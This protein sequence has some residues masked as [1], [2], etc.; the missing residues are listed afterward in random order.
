[1]SSARVVIVGGGFAGASA[2]DVL[3]AHGILVTLITGAPGAS[4]MTS[5]AFDVQSWTDHDGPGSLQGEEG[6]W[7]EDFLKRLLLLPQRDTKGGKEWVATGAGVIRPTTRAGALILG[8]GPFSGRRIGVARFLGPGF[9]SQHLER[10]YRDSPFARETGTQFCVVDLPSVFSASD[11]DLPAGATSHLLESEEACARLAQGLSFVERCDPELSAVLLPPCFGARFSFPAEF[12]LPVG[13]ILS[14]PEGAFGERVSVALSS[15]LEESP[16]KVV[17][18]NVS[19][20]DRR[21]ADIEITTSLV[22]EDGSG[23]FSERHLTDAL[24]LAP[25]GLIGGGI[26]IH[27]PSSRRPGFFGLFPSVSPPPVDG[28][29]DGF[30]AARKGP[31]FLQGRGKRAFSVLPEGVHVAGE[32]SSHAEDPVT[33]VIG[34]VLSGRR[35]ALRVLEDLKIRVRS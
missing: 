22:S 3:C 8:L 2:A 33:T 21:G 30:D 14:G 4:A 17:Q 19:S 11:H 25:G 7:A 35:A 27:P 24:I 29:R 15:F 28:S 32:A 23:H 12:P 18:G 1:M 9:S 16:G 10:E 13:E 6:E 26:R 20:V 31:G 34:S 5:G